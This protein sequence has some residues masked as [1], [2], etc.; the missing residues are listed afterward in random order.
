METCILIPREFSLMLLPQGNQGRLLEMGVTLWANCDLKPGL[1]FAPDDG[2]MR[3]D[4]LEIYSHLNER[5]VSFSIILLVNPAA[6]HKLP[7]I[8]HMTYISGVYS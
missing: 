7:Y 2:E 4:K 1:T 8:V 6:L 3:L 5:D